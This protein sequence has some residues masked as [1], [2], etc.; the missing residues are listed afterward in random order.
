MAI[1]QKLLSQLDTLV[2]QAF[3]EYSDLLKKSASAD[4]AKGGQ[5][6]S[7]EGTIGPATQDGDPI[8]PQDQKGGLTGASASAPAAPPMTKAVPPGFAADEAAKESEGAEDE[9]DEEAAQDAD[10]G[11][12]CDPK[13]ADEASDK[14]GDG[15][16]DKEDSDDS[17]AGPPK[18]GKEE[19]E[20]GEGD[21][22]E[23]EEGGDV[24]PK[25][26]GEFEKC[27]YRFM[28]EHGM[29]G[30]DVA[31]SEGV[32]VDGEPMMKAFDEK[33]AKMASAQDAR[34]VKME[35][36]MAKALE[37]INK[38]ANA[39]VAARKAVSGVSPV[40]RKSE[41]GSEAGKPVLSKAQVCEK[42]LDMQKAG[43]KRITRTIVAAVESAR[44]SEE[45]AR[46][47]NGII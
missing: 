38:I 20:S 41:D 31:K 37:T 43:D 7:V 39:P 6:S 25:F 21:E 34:L 27:F 40:L 24:D 47:V 46:L 22:K 35:Q 1:N 30:D 16:S 10:K 11:D 28:D 33:I 3:D 5:L 42:L 15:Q 45:I 2:D 18:E 19:G 14:D 29:G 17:E 9:A 26:Y 32:G 44:S 23:G 36:M 12:D 4:L 8:A 13:S